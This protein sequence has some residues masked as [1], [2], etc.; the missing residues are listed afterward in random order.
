MLFYIALID[1]ESIVNLYLPE[2]LIFPNTVLDYARF[3]Y[4]LIEA[5]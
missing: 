3:E 2:Q 5:L 1:N 4:G